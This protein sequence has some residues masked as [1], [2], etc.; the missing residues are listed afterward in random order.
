MPLPAACEDLIAL[1][2]SAPSRKPATA[3]C[4]WH[5]DRAGRNLR[6]LGRHL[7]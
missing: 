3:Y 5:I 1:L 2:N 4:G 6:R 7:V